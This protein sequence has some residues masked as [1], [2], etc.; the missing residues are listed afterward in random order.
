MSDDNESK[1]SLYPG[2]YGCYCN[3]LIAAIMKSAIL[4]NGTKMADQVVSNRSNDQ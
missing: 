4:K 3:K 1:R 2:E